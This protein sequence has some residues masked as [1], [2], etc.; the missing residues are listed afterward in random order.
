MSQEQISALH[1]KI[2][3]LHK[4]HGHLTYSQQKILNWWKVESDFDALDEERLE[5]L[6][7][8]KGR[9]AELQDHLASAMKLIADIEGEDTRVFT[10]VLNYMVQLDVLDDIEGWRAVRD[11]RNTASH[12][13]SSSEAAKASHFNDLLM[14]KNYLDQIL[15]NLLRF[16]AV[17]Y[18]QK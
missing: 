6:A 5:S 8:F 18:P 17:A 3:H 10:Y 4:M 2:E 15:D 14:H 11:L 12:D 13:Y 9:F 1:E 16:V 7:A